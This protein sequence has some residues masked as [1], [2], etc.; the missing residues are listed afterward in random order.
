MYAHRIFFQDFLLKAN[1]L[2]C[3]YYLTLSTKVYI[4]KDT[5][6]YII[7]SKKVHTLLR[8]TTLSNDART[9]KN[10]FHDL[11]LVYHSSEIGGLHSI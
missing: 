4:F 8:Y 9:E 3:A 1:L 10:H 7:L 2:L 11:M 6:Y 5:I